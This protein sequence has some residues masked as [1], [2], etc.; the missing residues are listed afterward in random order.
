MF[1]STMILIVPFL[2][3]MFL[4]L[5]LKTFSSEELNQMGVQMEGS[6]LEPCC[7]SN[8]ILSQVRVVCGNV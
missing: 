5:A 3:V 2:M 4:P 7:E 6:D 1:I 8:P